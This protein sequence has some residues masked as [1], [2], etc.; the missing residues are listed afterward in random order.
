MDLDLNFTVF[1]FN[2]DGHCEEIVGSLGKV[3]NVSLC[4]IESLD[5][6]PMMDRNF[7]QVLFKRNNVHYKK[8]AI[9]AQDALPRPLCDIVVNIS[10]LLVPFHVILIDQSVRVSTVSHFHE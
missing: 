8:S 9:T 10:P 2:H 3:D 4:V 6:G 5:E 1:D 7:A